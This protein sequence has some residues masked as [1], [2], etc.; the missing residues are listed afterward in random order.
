ME[1]KNKFSKMVKNDFLSIEIGDLGHFIPTFKV[2]QAM[3]D[4]GHTCH[5]IILDY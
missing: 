5:I 4:R 2:I 1:I 3:A